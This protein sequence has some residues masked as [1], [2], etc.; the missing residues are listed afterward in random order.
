MRFWCEN[1]NKYFNVEETL[2]EYYYFLNEDVIVCPSC[3][4]DLIPI[5]S[6]T[7]LS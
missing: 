3:K 2:Q 6:K 1:C 4:R 5:A 7:E